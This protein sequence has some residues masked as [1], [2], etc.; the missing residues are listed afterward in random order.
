MFV[1]FSLPYFYFL[2]D[3]PSFAYSRSCFFMNKSKSSEKNGKWVVSYFLYQLFSPRVILTTGKQVI[4]NDVWMPW[5]LSVIMFILNKLAL[6]Y[7]QDVWARCH[8]GKEWVHI[9]HYKCNNHFCFMPCH[10]GYPS[11]EVCINKCSIKFFTVCFYFW[12]FL[13]CNTVVL[14]TTSRLNNKVVFSSG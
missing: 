4:D 2:F 5:F 8:P 1:L 7:M 9:S 3:V 10:L 6:R 13:Q 11:E 14:A 12:Q